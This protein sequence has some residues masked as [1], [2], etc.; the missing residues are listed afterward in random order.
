MDLGERIEK[1]TMKL[2]FAFFVCFCGSALHAGWHSW[3]KGPEL[4]SLYMVIHVIPGLPPQERQTLIIQRWGGKDNIVFV[5]SDGWWD[6]TQ[7]DLWKWMDQKNKLIYFPSGTAGSD[8]LKSIFS[9][10]ER[11]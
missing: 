5:K 8:H 2:V 7:I 10:L 4:S 6:V 9:I 11:D 3:E 1:I